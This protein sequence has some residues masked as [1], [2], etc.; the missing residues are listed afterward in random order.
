MGGW[1]HLKPTPC[2]PAVGADAEAAHQNT[3]RFP[4][5][6]PVRLALAMAMLTFLAPALRA[7]GQ[8]NLPSGVPESFTYRDAEGPGRLDLFDLGPDDA[9]GGRRIKINLSQ[10]AVGYSGAGITLPLQ[11]T[12]PFTTLITFA[13]L[14]PG[15]VS[16]FF[17]GK[18]I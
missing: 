9:T 6:H 10:N 4:M 13:L 12:P 16:Y 7:Q 2:P 14:S 3:M 5:R 1:L 8:P 15:G 11:S 17:Q 18:L